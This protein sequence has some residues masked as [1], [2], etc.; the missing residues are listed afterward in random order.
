MIKAVP[1]PRLKRDWKRLKFK[2]QSDSYPQNLFD[3]AV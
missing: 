2:V 3:A 1:S